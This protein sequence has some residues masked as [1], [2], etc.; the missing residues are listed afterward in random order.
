MKRLILLLL[1]CGALAACTQT[2]KQ[3]QQSEQSAQTEVRAEGAVPQGEALLN[4]LNANKQSLAVLNNDSLSYYNGRGVSDLLTLLTDEPDR[5]KGAIVADKMVGR[6]AAVLMAAAGVRE[7]HTNIISTPA[8]KVL[9]EAGI[10]V[11]FN[12]E[13]PQILNRDQSGQCPID[14]SLNEAESVDECV[15]ILKT[16]F[17]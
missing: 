15:A 4:I 2:A 17:Q 7:V 5:L 12:E 16:R 13:V 14:A 9:R 1:A 10:S 8:L 6:A 11:S 3:K